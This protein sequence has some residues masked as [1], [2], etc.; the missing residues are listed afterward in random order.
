MNEDK[1]K[2]ILEWVMLVSVA[3]LVVLLAMS[4][5]KVGES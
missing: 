3:L 4:F 5:I 1:I 2:S